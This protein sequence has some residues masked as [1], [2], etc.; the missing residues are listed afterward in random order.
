MRSLTR[1]RSAG[2]PRLASVLRPRG[3]SAI[4]WRRQ[5]GMARGGRASRKAAGPLPR[6]GCFS[7]A[8]L[9]SPKAP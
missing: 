1:R 9:A 3:H 2:A 5:Q 6:Q 8:R 4:C 7:G